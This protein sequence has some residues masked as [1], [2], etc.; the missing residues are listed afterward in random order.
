MH[1]QDCLEL[2]STVTTGHVAMNHNALPAIFT[3]DLAVE[4]NEVVFRAPPGTKIAGN[5][6]CVH[7]DGDG[8]SVSVT[9]EAL[10]E[11]GFARVAL[12]LVSGQSA[13]SVAQ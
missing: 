9:G 6:V 7:A 11:D 2:L 8:W 12:E 10:V 4:G 3:I 13:A 1:R 5:V